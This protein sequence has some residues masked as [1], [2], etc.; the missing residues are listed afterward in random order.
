VAILRSAFAATMQ[1]AAFLAEAEKAR[2]IIVPT[3]G[4]RMEQLIRR[5]YG[6]PKEVVARAREL[7]AQ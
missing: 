2:L 4:D 1:D 5:A 6:A 7:I 3:S